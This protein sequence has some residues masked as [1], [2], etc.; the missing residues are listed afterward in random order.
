MKVNSPK[1]IDDGFLRKLMLTPVY[2]CKP[3]M[4][5]FM[6]KQYVRKNKNIIRNK[7]FIDCRLI[8]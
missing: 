4:P 8:F 3:L 2:S 6:V 1:M 5:R 7:L